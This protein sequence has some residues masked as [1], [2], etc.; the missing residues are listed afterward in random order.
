MLKP[1]LL[2]V[3]CSLLTGYAAA[4][5]NL[6]KPKNL[7]I[8]SITSCSV[9]A[10]WTPVPGASYY[11]I[12]YKQ[13]PGA[14]VYINTGTAASW[15][16]QGL[17]ANKN[18]YFSVAAFCSNNVT[19][20]YSKQIKIKTLICSAPADVVVSTV[21]K[22]KASI[23]WTAVC[24]GS[25]FNLQYRK[26]GEA[27]WITLSNILTPYVQLIQ[28]T[29]GTQYEFRLQTNCG[30]AGS[31][32]TS[33]QTFTTKGSAPETK[34]NIVAIMVDDGRYDIYQPNG[35]PAWFETPA[36]NR[37]ANEGVNFKYNFPATSQCAPSRATFYTGLYPHHHGCI[38]NSDHMNDSLPLIQQILKDNGYYTGFVGKYGQNLGLPQGFDWWAISLSDNYED[39]VYTINDVDTFI[40]G[41]ISDVYPQLA[42]E[43]LNQVPE[44]QPFALFYFHRAPHG[45]TVPRPEDAQLYLTDTIPFPSNFY[46]YSH[47]YPSFYYASVYKWPYDSLETDTARLLE[48]QSIAGVEANTDTLTAW[49]ESKN[50]LD[51]TFLLYTSDNGY[52]RGEHL[53]QGKGLAQEESLK[54]PMFIRYPKWFAP[55]T[56]ISDELSANIDIAPTMLEL[57]GIPDTF[58]MDGVSMHQLY[59]HAVSRKEF[60]Y[61][62]GG[63]ATVV[64]PIR[65]VRTL[66][67]KYT[68]YYCNNQVEDFFDLVNDPLENN[69]LIGNNAYSALIQDYRVKLDSLRNYFGDYEPVE[70]PCSLLHPTLMKNAEPAE[71]VN[72]SFLFMAPNP[73]ND[74]FN[75][76]YTGKQNQAG[77]ITIT[78][79]LGMPVFYDSVDDLYAA[80]PVDCK[81]WPA[82]VYMV[83]LRTAS[84]L[85]NGRI[86]VSH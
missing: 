9:V 57:A 78:N 39:V 11:M 44:G 12:R 28:L 82:G 13:G 52:I 6:M 85:I 19:K 72:S 18:Y 58:G 43:F 50:I 8:N 15:Q 5:C 37:I 86:S 7:A 74:H 60:F 65:S 73:A 32:L 24:G 16:V 84:G 36:I 59:T 51:N 34:P 14:F 33:I 45:P 79:T 71:L 68:N 64:P 17:V 62:F 21:T 10:S 42:L 53:L 22:Y 56:V 3:F 26:Q 55:G 20:G 41:H 1:V 75:L 30:N 61:E 63:T 31:D 54:L 83:N 49:L 46:K 2:L 23:Q 69:N 47:D 38:V 48:Y 4:Q 67:Y 66:Q 76:M 80:L 35:G 81:A 27:A 29:P 70:I 77:V 25:N 40:P